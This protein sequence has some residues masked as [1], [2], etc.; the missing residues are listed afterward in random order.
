MNKSEQFDN[1][2]D[3]LIRYLG[4]HEMLVELA[5]LAGIAI[6]TWFGLRRLRRGL[7]G[8]PG[9]HD[10]LAATDWNRLVLP[11][12]ML[13]LVLIGRLL[14]GQWQSVHL[15]N[16]AVPL[17]LSFLAIQSCF[18]ILRRV[19]KPQLIAIFIGVIAVAIIV[20]GYLFNLIA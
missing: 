17:L 13:P 10:S 11:A 3:P 6:V 8:V 14:I 5:A 1:L 19:L 16:L 7:S 12:S 20:T 9:W 18:F 15:F 2:I 4:N